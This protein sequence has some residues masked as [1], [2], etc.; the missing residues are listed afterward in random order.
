MLRSLWVYSSRMEG[1]M[2]YGEWCDRQGCEGKKP[3]HEICPVCEKAWNAAIKQR[4]VA[5][6]AALEKTMQGIVLVYK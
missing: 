4:N 6:S 2:E 1:N 5:D 3:W